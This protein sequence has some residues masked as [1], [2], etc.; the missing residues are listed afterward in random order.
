MHTRLSDAQNIRSKHNYP[1][2]GILGLILSKRGYQKIWDVNNAAFIDPNKYLTPASSL[3][4]LLSAK[5]DSRFMASLARCQMSNQLYFV[6][7]FSR[8]VRHSS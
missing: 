7:I 2:A 4:C 1:A 6:E 5:P 3:L 8:C